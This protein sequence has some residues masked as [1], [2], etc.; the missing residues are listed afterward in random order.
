MRMWLK[1]GV[2]ALVL[3][4]QNALA[5]TV[6]VVGDSISAA[7]GLETEQGWVQLLRERIAET[8][9]E[10]AVVN[11]SVSGDT[12]AGGLSRLD[13]L[14]AEHRPQ[15]VIIELGGNDGLRGQAPAQLQQNLARMVDKSRQAGAEV[16]LLG[17]QLPPNYGRRYTEAFAEVFSQVAQDKQV[18]LVPFFLEGVGGV[19][20]MMQPDGIHP[21]ARAQARLLQNV[22]PALEP[23]L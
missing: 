5:G 11:A 18:A 16:L 20:S 23:L 14:L 19:A 3:W 15:V 10:L 1:G 7:F 12:S 2:L 21:A 6:L 13:S 17:M 22:W 4:A 8:G 9:K